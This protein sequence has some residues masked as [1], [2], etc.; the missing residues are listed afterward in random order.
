MRLLDELEQLALGVTTVGDDQ[1]VHVV[2]AQDARDG[3]EA[4]EHGQVACVAVRS[5]RAE[6]LVSDAAA[7]RAEHPPQVGELFSLSDEHRSPSRAGKAENVAA[8]AARNS[9]AGSR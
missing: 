6:V 8:S 2:L 4:A 7:I 1:L 9:R 5:D 3:V